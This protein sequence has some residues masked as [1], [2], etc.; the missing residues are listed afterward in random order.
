VL[1][2]VAPAQ[3]AQVEKLAPRPEQLQA[4]GQEQKVKIKSH[5][6]VAVVFAALIPI[7]LIGK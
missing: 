4:A 2:E 3:Q 1:R 5:N 6:I 7:M